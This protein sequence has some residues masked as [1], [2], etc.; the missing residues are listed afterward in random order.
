MKKTR[1][2]SEQIIGKLRQADVALGKG[3]IVPEIC[4]EL[5]ITEQTYYRRHQSYDVDGR[6]HHF[7]SRVILIY[8]V[9]AYGNHC[10]WGFW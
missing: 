7:V 6:V 2:T 3:R 1:H 9:A 5:Q 8:L 4:K 10:R